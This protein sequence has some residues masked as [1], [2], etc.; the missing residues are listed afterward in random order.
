MIFFSSTHK[1]TKI[2]HMQDHKA[3]LNKSQRTGVIQTIFP[4]HSTIKLITKKKIKL[5]QIFTLLNSPQVKEKIHN[6]K[7][8][9]IFKTEQ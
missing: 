1:M 6:G 9:L 7:I 4:D 3:S 8:F 5:T 2:N